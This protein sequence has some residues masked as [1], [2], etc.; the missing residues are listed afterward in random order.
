MEV[1]G[2]KLYIVWVVVVDAYGT[3]VELYLQGENDVLGGKHY[4]V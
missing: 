2:G 4:I 1:L 3:M